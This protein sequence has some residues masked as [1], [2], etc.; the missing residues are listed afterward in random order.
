MV[1]LNRGQKGAARS[2]TITNALAVELQ[3]YI[4]HPYF[5]TWSKNEDATLFFDKNK[6][7]SSYKLQKKVKELCIEA[8]LSR[9]VT[10]HDLRRTAGYLMQFS[11]MHIVEIQQQLG[12]KILSTTLR[13]V[14]PLENLAKI[15]LDTEIK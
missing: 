7:L 15:L 8:G 5:G 13:Y 10:P 2:T 11:G 6:P 12:H 3:R 9:T 1:F 14:P 4:G